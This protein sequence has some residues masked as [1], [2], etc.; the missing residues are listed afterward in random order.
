[1]ALAIPCQPNLAQNQA[2]LQE[3]RQTLSQ[4][5]VRGVRNLMIRLCYYFGS[6]KF[7]EPNRQRLDGGRST[8]P[9]SQL[10][11]SGSHLSVVEICGSGCTACA[12]LS[13]E[14][15]LPETA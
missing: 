4:N 14:G 15:A 6:T 12:H 2:Y 13:P 10:R 8:S 3:W 5:R 7:I 9:K 1:M 11:L